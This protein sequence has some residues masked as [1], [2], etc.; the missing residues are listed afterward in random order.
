M[1]ENKTERGLNECCQKWGEIRQTVKE[2]YNG[3]AKKSKRSKS[4]IQFEA[5]HEVKAQ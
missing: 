5:S 2:T 4:T 3:G 1:L